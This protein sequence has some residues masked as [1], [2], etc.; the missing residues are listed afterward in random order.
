M[1]VIVLETYNLTITTIIT[2]HLLYIFICF[3]YK[4]ID[5]VKIYLYNSLKLNVVYKYVCNT[6]TAKFYHTTII[7]ELSCKKNPVYIEF[8]LM[9]WYCIIVFLIADILPYALIFSTR[10]LEQ[11]NIVT[12]FLHISFVVYV[13]WADC[14]SMS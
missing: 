10:P 13:L 4:N 5:W 3:A 6:W 2:V 14:V 1:Y 12:L 8:S 11:K 7:H 9:Y